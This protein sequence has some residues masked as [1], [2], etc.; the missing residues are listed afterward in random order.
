MIMLIVTRIQSFLNF[1]RARSSFEK[2]RSINVFVGRLY[3]TVA[4][5]NSA[6]LSKHGPVI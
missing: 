4:T 3:E 2:N 1:N 5:Q 6:I